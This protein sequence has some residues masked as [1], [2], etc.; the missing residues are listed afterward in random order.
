L[1]GAG[2][3]VALETVWREKRRLGWTRDNYKDTR[4][5]KNTREWTAS[6]V[7]TL[8]HCGSDLDGDCMP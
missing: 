1:W 6:G 3:E 2:E 5:W 7:P 4:V 8:F